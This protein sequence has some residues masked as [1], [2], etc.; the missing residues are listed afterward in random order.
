MRRVYIKVAVDKRHV[1]DKHAHATEFILDLVVTRTRIQYIIRSLHHAKVS[2]EYHQRMSIF[3][4]LLVLLKNCNCCLSGARG[5]S[6][7]T[8]RFAF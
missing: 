7:K 2:L 1:N 8:R 4:Q 6:R 3:W 5:C